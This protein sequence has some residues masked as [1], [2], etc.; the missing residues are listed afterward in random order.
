[1]TLKECYTVMGANYEEVLNR[2]RSEKLIRK[3][4]IRFLDD[5]SY[6]KL[7][8]ALAAEDGDGAFLAAHTIKGVS[9]NLGFTRLYETSGE[10]TEALRG[11]QLPVDPALVENV[12]NAYEVTT[13]AIRKLAA[14]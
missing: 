10:L 5:D 6:A 1:M 14:E 2:L 11:R 7:Q 9:Q 13:A 12:T 3:F 4:A 8:E